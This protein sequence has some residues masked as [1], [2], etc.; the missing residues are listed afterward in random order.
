MKKLLA[1]LLVGIIWVF[2]S[3]E[4]IF[5]GALEDAK[6]ITYTVPAIDE[7]GKVAAFEGK[8]YNFTRNGIH[9]NGKVIFQAF[10]ITEN[11]RVVA[12]RFNGTIRA[13][14][15]W[16]DYSTRQSEHKGNYVLY[17]KDCNGTYETK[18]STNDDFI[19]PECY[20]K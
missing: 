20:V 17:D 2:M 10:E 16:E 11:K 18:I 6:N 4:K 12:V 13:W 15:I 8:L 3:S 7:H 5:A 14:V 1:L 9:N 19:Y